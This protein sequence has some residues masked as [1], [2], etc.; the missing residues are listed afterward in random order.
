MTSDCYC[1][2]STDDWQVIAGVCPGGR[3]TT[4]RCRVRPIRGGSPAPSSVPVCTTALVDPTM[5]SASAPTDG[6]DRNAT[7]VRRSV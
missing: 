3:V 7:K 5:A 6:P 4:V 1:Y 2:C